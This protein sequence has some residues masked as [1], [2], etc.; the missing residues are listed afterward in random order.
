[1][2]ELTRCRLC[3]CPAK[4]SILEPYE[5]CCSNKGCKAYYLLL[6][7]N[8]WRRLMYV[9]EKKPVPEPNYS[10]PVCQNEWEIAEAEGWNDC[11]DAMRKGE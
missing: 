9:P 4:I 6:T 7:H 8:E 1:M 3:K 2:S 5:A 10:G 11:V